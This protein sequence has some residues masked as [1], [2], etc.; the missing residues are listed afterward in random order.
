MAI[1]DH[2]PPTIPRQDVFKYVSQTAD[3]IAKEVLN[4][5]ASNIRIFVASDTHSALEE[6]KI[7][8]PR[9]FFFSG[10]NWL[11]DGQGVPIT[12]H[13]NDEACSD[14]EQTVMLEAVL[15]G[16]A[17]VLMTPQWSE[18]TAISKNLALSRGAHWCQNQQWKGKDGEIPDPA[19]P[20]AVIDSVNASSIP[21]RS[22]QKAAASAMHEW[23]AILNDCPEFLHCG[24][25]CYYENQGLQ[26]RLI[27]P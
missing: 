16:Y 17:D 21:A 12:T 15:L 23:E 2:R 1:H 22:A 8:D 6:F 13:G 5:S 14:L 25:K 11:Q 3:R 19:K 9:V 20:N 4:V 27:Q 26:S 24:W 10:G 18:L 7:F